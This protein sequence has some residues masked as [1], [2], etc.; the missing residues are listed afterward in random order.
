M[1]GDSQVA[2]SSGSFAVTM[3]LERSIPSPNCIKAELNTPKSLSSTPSSPSRSS[4]QNGKMSPPVASASLLDRQTMNLS[5]IAAASRPIEGE[6]DKITIEMAEALKNCH[7]S[8]VKSL[9]N[10]VLINGKLDADKSPSDCISPDVC[11]RLLS[12]SE[13]M[14]LLVRN[15]TKEAKALV[16]AEM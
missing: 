8:K 14:N 6:D 2:A 3:D 16:Q 1:T 7:C 11:K 12:L 15:I 4:I 10:G 13:D 5:A 9:A